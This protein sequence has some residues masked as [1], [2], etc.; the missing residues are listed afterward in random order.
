[1]IL[2]DREIWMEVERGRLVFDPPLD[3]QQ[4]GPSSVDL[5]LSD[6]FLEFREPDRT[7]GMRQEVVISDLQASDF[8]SQYTHRRR[9]AGDEEYRLAPGRLVIGFTLESVTLPPYLAARVEGKSSLARVGLSVHITAPTVQAGFS[10][11]LALEM[12]NFGPYPLV[13]KRGDRVCQLVI[14]K[15]SSPPDSPYQGQFQRQ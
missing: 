6:V 12:Y 5:R 1:M 11:T 10:G 13:L 15:V 7:T 14:E 3:P 4:I 9:L 8:I 2:S